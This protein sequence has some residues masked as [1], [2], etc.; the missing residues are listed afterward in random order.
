MKHAGKSADDDEVESPVEKA[1]EKIVQALYSCSP[2]LFS[3]VA[4]IKAAS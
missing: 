4:R 1:P 2:A 3:S